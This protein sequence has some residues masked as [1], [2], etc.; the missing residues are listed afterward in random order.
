MSDPPASGRRRMG[1]CETTP[2]TTRDRGKP[3]S[4]PRTKTTHQEKRSS[5][6]I[7]GRRLPASSSFVL[8][9]AKGAAL[10][11]LQLDPDRATAQ[12]G[13]HEESHNHSPTQTR[14][15]RT[16]HRVDPPRPLD[17]WGP[18]GCG[19]VMWQGLSRIRRGQFPQISSMGVRVGFRSRDG[20]NV[21]G[22]SDRTLLVRDP[23]Q[24]R[25][26]I[27]TLCCRNRLASSSPGQASRFSAR[28]RTALLVGGAKTL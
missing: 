4:D 11:A 8:A 16:G 9:R 6:P 1:A 27:W 26:A 12:T 22:S 21:A 20:N 15:R 14:R 7:I 3:A 23:G 5:L 25:H 2:T 10:R 18:Y 24:V 28:S 17:S 19:Y 13:S